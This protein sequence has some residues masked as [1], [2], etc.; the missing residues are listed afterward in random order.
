[1]GVNTEVGRPSRCSVVDQLEGLVD[2]LELCEE[3]RAGNAREVAREFGGLGELK[4]HVLASQATVQVGIAI[5]TELRELRAEL[6][7]TRKT[8]RA[9]AR[10]AAPGPATEASSSPSTRKP[11]TGQTRRPGGGG[12]RKSPAGKGAAR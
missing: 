6:E 7:A 4:P 5:V 9:L 10:P 8:I 12:R 2:L 3:L 1:M 11:R